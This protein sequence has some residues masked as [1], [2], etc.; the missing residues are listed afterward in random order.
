MHTSNSRFTSCLGL[1]AWIISFFK[2]LSGNNPSN[3]EVLGVTKPTEAIR[4]L[5]KGWAPCTQRHTGPQPLDHMVCSLPLSYI[6]GWGWQAWVRISPHLRG[7]WTESFKGLSLV[8]KLMPR[9]LFKL[10]QF[11]FKLNRTFYLKSVLVVPRDTKR[12][13][14]KVFFETFLEPCIKTL[15]WEE[16]E[17]FSSLFNANNWQRFQTVMINLNKWKALKWLCPNSS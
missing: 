10:L 6:D 3:M 4:A 11:G 7:K 13:K 12:A 14:I 1:E 2:A 5:R 16:E 15:K 8:K 17:K 9:W